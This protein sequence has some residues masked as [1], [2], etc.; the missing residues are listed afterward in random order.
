MALCCPQGRGCNAP[1]S[2]QPCL[3]DLYRRGAAALPEASLALDRWE[4]WQ[5]AR[6][7]G[8]RRS[9]WRFRKRAYERARADALCALLM[10]AH[11]SARRGATRRARR[12]AG[13]T[14]SPAEPQPA[15]RLGVLVRPSGPGRR[16]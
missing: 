9:E 14:D 3:L 1:E 2:G 10:Y 8:C 6:E 4:E 12:G 15:T 16:R 11:T 7:R 5:T 13:A